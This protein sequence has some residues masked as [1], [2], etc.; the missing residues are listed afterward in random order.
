[1]TRS[2]PIPRTERV[3]VRRVTD[4]HL[5]RSPF[6]A[7]DQQPWQ[8]P[9]AQGSEHPPRPGQHGGPPTGGRRPPPWQ[10]PGSETC[11]KRAN[12][13]GLLALAVALSGAVL[14]C[15]PVV[16]PVG[17]LLLPVGFLLGVVAL[18]GT[19]R[20]LGAA[21]AALGVSVAGAGVAAVVGLL[22][23]D[24]S[25]TVDF[26]EGFAAGYAATSGQE[27]ATSV[28]TPAPIGTPPSEPVTG[29]GSR[30]EPFPIGRSLVFDEWEVTIDAIDLDGTN[31]VLDSRYP[32]D[33]PDPGTRYALV[34][35]TSTYLGDGSAHAR[36][37]RFD[38]VTASGVVI[39]ST[40][41]HVMPPDPRHGDTELYAGGAHT[42][43]DA[44]Q[45]P[46]DEGGLLRVWVDLHGPRYFVAPG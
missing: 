18:F 40:D 13:L 46:Q 12:R 8:R 19:N 43:H 41:K 4:P 9:G 26:R 2:T 17:W 1:M 10:P 34:T 44:I 22:T 38:F 29:P 33:P 11:P 15:L 7:P 32:V 14:A 28:V 39:R 45:I 20:K 16:R 42:G 23:V 35:A 5:T 31:A 3:I 30:V 36:D 25:F 24:N 21:V 37:I 27:S 6:G